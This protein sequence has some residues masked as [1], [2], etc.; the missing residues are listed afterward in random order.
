MQ[1][2]TTTD[3]SP[4]ARRERLRG[5]SA[6]VSD[7]ARESGGV[8]AE[9]G[10]TGFQAILNEVLPVHHERNRDLHHLWADLPETERRLIE[11]PSDENVK[12]YRELVKSIAEEV[13]RS[14]MKVTTLKRKNRHGDAV[15]LNIVEVIDDRL[16]KMMLAL[17]SPQNTAFQILR[18]LSEIR[19]LLIDARK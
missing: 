13:V 11:D 8:S 6:R 9:E 17:Q 1:V 10:V 7:Q 18:T 16:Q 12:Q 5:A 15:E 4:R 19:G 2:R 3:S 14:N